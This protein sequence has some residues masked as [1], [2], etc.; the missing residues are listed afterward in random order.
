M[1][2]L[3]A[4]AM[5]IKVV[6]VGSFSA[7]SK[8]LDVPLPTLSRKISDLENQLGVRLLHRTTR[9]LSLTS[10]GIG[11]VNA[12][13][14]IVEQVEEAELDVKGEYSEPKGNLV[15]TAPVMFGRRY[16]LPIVNDFLS[17]H[18]NINIQL[19][20][21]DGNINLYDNEVDIAIRIGTLPD[22]SMIATSVGALRLITCANERVLNRDT[23]LSSPNDLVNFPCVSL[24]FSNSTLQWNYLQPDTKL[25]FNVNI[26]PRLIITDS[27]S[28]VRAAI[29]GIGVTQQLHYQ[30][31]DAIDSGDLKIVL[32]EFEPDAIPVHL[33]H[34]S[35]RYM[36]QKM[37]SFLDFASPRLK[38][39]LDALNSD[40]NCS[41]RND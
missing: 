17:L 32:Q 30:V 6:E 39:K 24:K 1:D 10:S 35:R 8:A 22:S 7:A 19:E 25:N 23:N 33:M 13:K 36:P 27:E 18:S 9:K 28:V 41:L 38:S 11:Y 12:C 37:R 34:K 21:S 16:V 40:V 14:R 2:R 26:Y 3:Q 31:K 5:L 4:M 20:L 15:I 29:S